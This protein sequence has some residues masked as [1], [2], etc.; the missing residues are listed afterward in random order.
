M[1]YRDNEPG[2]FN[3]IDKVVGTKDFVNYRLTGEIVTDNSYASGSGVYELASGSYSKPLVAA[4]DV[5]RTILPEIVPSTQVIGGL[6]AEAAEELSLPAGLPVVAG[7]V[8]NSCLALG[9]R[10]VAEGRVY[11]SLGSSSWIAVSSREATP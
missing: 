10:S 1:W 3:R 7:G 8:D 4:A 9:A 6:V 11:N 2:M 5:P